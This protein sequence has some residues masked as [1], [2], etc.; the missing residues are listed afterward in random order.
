MGTWEIWAGVMPRVLS[1]AV[2][3]VVTI[4]RGGMGGPGGFDAPQLS[5][6]TFVEQ[7]RAYLLA[8]DDVKQAAKL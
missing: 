7:R 3:P 1:A 5:L 2:R 6:K 8:L 4:G